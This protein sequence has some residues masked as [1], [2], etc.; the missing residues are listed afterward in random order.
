MQCQHIT[1]Y[2]CGKKSANNLLL[3]AAVFSVLVMAWPA[4]SHADIYKYVDASGKVYFTDKPKNKKYRLIIS[5][6][7]ATKRRYRSV[8][9]KIVKQRRKKVEPII[10]RVADKHQ[11][12]PK[13]LHAIIQ[14]ESAY[15]HLAVSRAGAV[16][17]MQLMPATARQYGVTNRRDPAQSIEGGARYL[18]K[19]LAEFSSKDLAIAAYNAGEGAVHK[20]GNRIPPYKETRTYVK[21]VLRNYKGQ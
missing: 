21:R 14:A 3:W 16:G 5:A 10:A 17:L 8:T 9:S 12:D 13:L 7:K 2:C 18:K 19:L 6:N 11:L 20:Y 4:S 1:G 15:D